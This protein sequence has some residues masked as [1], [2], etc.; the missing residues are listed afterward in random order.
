[1]LEQ[2]IQQQFFDSADLKYA[3]AE[4]LA[5]PIADAVNAVVGCI[6]AGGKVLACGNGGS[7]SDA[8]HFAAEFVGRFERERPGLAAIA[9]TTDTSILTAVGNDYDFNSIFSKQVQ[10][11][12]SPGDVLLAITT[13]GNSANVLAA[14][15]AAKAK[16]MTVIALT[17]RGGGKMR[18]RLGETG[19]AHPR[20]AL[21]VRCG[22]S[23]AARRTGKHMTTQRSSLHRPA[24]L[25]AGLATATLMSACA[26]LL[27]GGAVVGTSMVVTDRRT[28]G[29]QLE[30]QAIEL[31][32]KT[33]VREAVGERGHVNITSYNR[34]VLL[35]GEVAADVD[36]VAVEQA[37]AKIEGVRTVVNELAVMGSSSIASRSNDA[38]LTSKVK[39]SYI[40]AKDVFANAIKVTTERGTVYLMGRVTEREANRAS[41]IARG[42]AGVQ[43][44]VKVFEV[45]SE[46]ELAEI[47]P[48]QA[49]K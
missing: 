42:V 20:A 27:V 46:A 30:D 7:A 48:K 41:D 45:I 35:T 10:A 23:A 36:K 12:G 39:A 8:Q 37:V 40:D 1:M 21:P 44:V 17:G 9:L 34:T 29:T 6:T 24:L 47:Q 15:D 49:S 5:K 26:P 38:V 16:D 19:G 2:R 33:R 43:K 4:I 3:A 32:A 22:R 11:L 31:K 28:S 25:L 18:E 13:S 14:V